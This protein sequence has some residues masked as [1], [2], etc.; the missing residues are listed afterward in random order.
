MLWGLVGGHAEL[1]SNAPHNKALT[2]DISLV[3]RPAPRVLGQDLGVYGL[4]LN[5]YINLTRSSHL[6][7][8][9]CMVTH[10]EALRASTGSML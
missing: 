2:L 10:G 1:C 5:L 7:F 8:H 3:V 9:R 6:R 4:N